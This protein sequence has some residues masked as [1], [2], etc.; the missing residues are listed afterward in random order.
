M[1]C[2]CG[3]SLA[4]CA[5]ESDLDGC[6]DGHDARLARLCPDCQVHVTCDVSEID[7]RIECTNPDCGAPLI[8]REHELVMIVGC[9]GGCPDVPEDELTSRWRWVDD[10][11]RAV[12]LCPLCLGDEDRRRSRERR[13]EADED[14]QGARDRREAMGAGL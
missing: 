6:T 14:R 2:P 1:T 13:L 3:I 10:E 4:S 12:Q 9:D 11:R 5:R 7:A 8:V